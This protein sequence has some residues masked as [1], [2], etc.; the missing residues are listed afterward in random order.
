MPCDPN[1]AT[2]QRTRVTDGI[3]WPLAHCAFSGCNWIGDNDE[4]LRIHVI[5]HHAALLRHTISSVQTLAEEDKDAH[6]LW[7]FYCAAVEEKERECIPLLGPTRD[8]RAIH[9]LFQVL[10]M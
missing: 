8:R 10:V 1:D 5:S 6:V 4:Q 7:T 9:R 2:K 3:L